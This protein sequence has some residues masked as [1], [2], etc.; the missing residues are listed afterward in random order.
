MEKVIRDG[1]VAVLISPG[2]GAGWS[3][4]CDVEICDSILF[5]P[6]VVAWVEGGKVGP[7]PDM[8]AKYGY[9]QDFFTDAAKTLVIKWVP[10]GTQFRIEEYDG[11]ESIHFESDY[12]WHTA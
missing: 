12:R 4:D 9:D 10:V 11:F 5:D 1:K 6:D 7:L 3:T 2:Y 8:T